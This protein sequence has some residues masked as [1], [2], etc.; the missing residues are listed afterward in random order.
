MVP[1]N[2]LPSR[3]Y[4]K[5]KNRRVMKKIYL[6]IMLMFCCNAYAASDYLSSAGAA[7]MRVLSGTG[8]A[9]E[10]ATRIQPM[11]A[12]DRAAF[13]NFISM[14]AYNDTAL[15]IFESDAH[16]SRALDFMAQPLTMR[17]NTCPV[18]VTGC[19]NGRHSLVI[20]GG[21]G[22]S[23]ADYS[24]SNNSDFKTKT[25]DIAIRAKAFVSN[26]VAFGVGYTRTDTDNRNSPID[27]KATGN[28]VTMFAQ[29]LSESGI[30]ANVGINAGSIA[31]RSDKTIVGVPDDE[32]YNTNFWGGQI[33]TGAQIVAGQFIM[34]PQ[35]SNSLNVFKFVIYFNSPAKVE[36]KSCIFARLPI[37]M[38]KICVK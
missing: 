8:A 5:Q 14:L 31:W 37:K 4:Y 30:F 22:A 24:P 27:I 38:R 6:F 32:D 19:K 9:G 15:T 21:A 3:P 13:A 2:F 34:T 12:S 25:T 20:D 11:Q 36:K 28:S 1:V 17:R 33:N 10:I 26:S 29:Y 16:M 35:I 18:N 7:W 23:F